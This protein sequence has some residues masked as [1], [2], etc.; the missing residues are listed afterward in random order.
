MLILPIGWMKPKVSDKIARTP[1]TIRCENSGTD[2]HAHRTSMPRAKQES[3]FTIMELLLVLTL[4]GI[5]SA[6]SMPTLKGFAATRR[7]KASA[8][9]IRSLITF[10]RD[11]AV[12]DRA[13]YL[14]V[15]DLDNGRYWLASSETFNPANPLTS[16]LTAQNS[17]VSAAAQNRENANLMTPGT[18]QRPL[19]RTSGILGVPYPLEPDVTFVGMTTLRNGRTTEIDT[20]VDYIYFSPTATA[21]EVL[22]Y[23]RNARDQIIALTVEAASARVQVRQLT[24]EEVQLLGLQAAP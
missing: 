20:G 15:F 8:A 4:I 22:L 23:L 6:I 10:A 14:V 21:E 9:S 13:A 17:T 18:T 5:L 1:A 7:L 24:T 2:A 16:T 11:M 12:T 19:E 3:G